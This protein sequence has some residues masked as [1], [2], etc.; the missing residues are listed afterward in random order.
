MTAPPHRIPFDNRLALW[1]A[2]LAGP[3][4]WSLHLL[5]SYAAVSLACTFIFPDPP[6]P[7]LGA[8]GLAVVA[9]T[10]VAALVTL[11]G[12]IYCVHAWRRAG[13]SG[14][15]E[16]S[17]AEAVGQFMAVGGVGLNA[18]FLLATILEGLP[19]LVLRPCL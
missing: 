2:V 14:W 18:L 12:G 6:L 10:L 11:A 9:I 8:G 7:G 16:L 19:V 4:A 5:V 3:L 15:R 17:R 13:G 1:L